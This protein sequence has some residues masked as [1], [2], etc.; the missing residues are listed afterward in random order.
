MRLHP[1]GPVTNAEIWWASRSIHYNYKLVGL[2][3][4]FPMGELFFIGLAQSN[5]LIHFLM[6]TLHMKGN[7]SRS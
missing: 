2:Q 5:A 7:R 4:G 6:K 1:S 3:M